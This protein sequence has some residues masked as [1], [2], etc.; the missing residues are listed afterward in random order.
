[1]RTEPFIGTNGSRLE[2]PQKTRCASHPPQAEATGA[3]VVYSDG[4]TRIIP[5]WDPWKRGCNLCS[6]SHFCTKW[7]NW[8][9]NSAL[10]FTVRLAHVSFPTNYSFLVLF[11]GPGPGPPQSWSSAPH[12]PRFRDK[13][14]RR[15]RPGPAYGL[16]HEKGPLRLSRLAD[17]GEVS[18]RSGCV[19]SPL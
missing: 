18:S 3:R 17:L 2:E 9:R 7:T 15:L 6:S 1:M 13:G 10:I 12:D 14:R 11:I 16:A 19:I 5:W 8:F 4:Q